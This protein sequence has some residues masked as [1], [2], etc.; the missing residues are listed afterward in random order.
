MLGWPWGS[1]YDS[2]LTPRSYTPK[3]RKG[4]CLDFYLRF[5]QERANA[6]WSEEGDINPHPKPESPKEVA[7]G[8]NKL[9]EASGTSD[10]SQL[11]AL[12]WGGG[13][14][15]QNCPFPVP[16]GDRSGR[17]PSRKQAP[18]A[19]GAAGRRRAQPSQKEP[20]RGSPRPGSSQRKQAER[21]RQREE[22]GEQGRSSAERTFEGRRKRDG[23][24]SLKEQRAPPKKEKEVPRKEEMWKR[25][26][27]H[28][29]VV[30]LIQVCFLTGT[31]FS[32][33]PSPSPDEGRRSPPLV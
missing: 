33:G 10:S 31:L 15:G 27:K 16:A 22:L 5:R 23:R 4:M 7:L 9:Q 20:A 13:Q 11:G 1:G 2:A 28:R 8:A 30:I 26:K 18:R 6:S 25:P 24:A 12:S 17:R 3:K 19:E 32:F 14:G 29:Y 21:R